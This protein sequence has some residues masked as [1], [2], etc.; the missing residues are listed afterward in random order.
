MC[1]K[2]YKK[3]SMCDEISLDIDDV[4]HHTNDLWDCI[5]SENKFN[6]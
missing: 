6:H 2:V 4:L 1:F 5:A 3:N